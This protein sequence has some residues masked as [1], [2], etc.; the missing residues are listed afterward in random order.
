[1]R[2]REPLDSTS[3][4]HA[5]DLVAADAAACCAPAPKARSAKKVVKRKS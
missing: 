4:V 5:L 1:M 2:R 3:F